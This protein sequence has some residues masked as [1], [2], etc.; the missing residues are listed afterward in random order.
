VLLLA[1]SVVVVT[2]LRRIPPIGAEQTAETAEPA[3]APDLVDATN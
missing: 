2:M 1:L 3:G